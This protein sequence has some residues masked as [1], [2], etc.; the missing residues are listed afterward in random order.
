[1]TCSFPTQRASDAEMHPC[2]TVIIVNGDLC[3]CSYLSSDMLWD[4]SLICWYLLG[5][6]ISQWMSQLGLENTT[7]LQHNDTTLHTFPFPFSNSLVIAWSRLLRYGH[8]VATVDG[9]RRKC[10]Q[11]VAIYRAKIDLI[12]HMFLKIVFCRTRIMNIVIWILTTVAID[13]V[14]PVTTT[15]IIKLI[16]CD[17]FSNV[18]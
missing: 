1:M 15:S 12:N 7:L 8:P 2:H 4:I 18:F 11:L 10:G 6:I 17:L 9:S 13:T 5:L 14:K 3:I 16:T